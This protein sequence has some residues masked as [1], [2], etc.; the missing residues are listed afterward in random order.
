MKRVLVTGG[1]GFI[2]SHTVVS[3]MEAGLQPVIFDNLCNS[4]AQVLE[5][6]SR[7]TGK[8]PDFV[9][10]DVTNH[11]SLCRYVWCIEVLGR[12]DTLYIHLRFQARCNL[13]YMTRVCGKLNTTT[14]VTIA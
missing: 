5:G 9:L 6:I 1:M 10:G 13:G 2:G 12:T 4:S 3:L 7:I 8:T 14:T 11:P